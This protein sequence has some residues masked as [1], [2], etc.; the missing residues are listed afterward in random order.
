MFTTKKKKQSK[1][2]ELGLISN[3]VFNFV[4]LHVNPIFFSVKAAIGYLKLPVSLL[5]LR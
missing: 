3:L 5:G 1:S 4:K 2:A